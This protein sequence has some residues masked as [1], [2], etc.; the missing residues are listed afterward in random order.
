MA[1][2]EMAASGGDSW[3]EALPKATR[4]HNDNSHPRLMGSAPND[5]KDSPELQ[6]TLEKEAGEDIA[7]NNAEHMK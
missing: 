2:R 5:V 4:A 6:Y 7:N 1:A 3:A